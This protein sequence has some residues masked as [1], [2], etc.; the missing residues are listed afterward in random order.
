[1]RVVSVSLVVAL[2][3]SPTLAL[4]QDRPTPLR[5]S[6]ERAAAVAAVATA[7]QGSDRVRQP[8][9]WSGLAL[10]IAGI[11]TAVL[12]VTAY[13]VEDTSTG[14]APNNAYQTC[15]A[16]KKDPIYA[17]NSCEALKGKNRALLWSGVAIGG[18]G[19]TLMIGSTHTSAEL[20]AGAVRLL[21]TIRF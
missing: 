1:M 19:A 12:G 2:A 9:F 8:M 21:H 20:S 6:A 13:R 10:G 7:E 17:S 11:T 16:Q 5:A 15:V 18:V 3:A 4:A 14:N